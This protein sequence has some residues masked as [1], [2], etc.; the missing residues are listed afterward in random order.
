MTPE[1]LARLAV[2]GLKET[3]VEDSLGLDEADRA[4]VALRLRLSREVMRLRGVRHLTQRDLAAIL[5]MSQP[6]VAG[7]EKAKGVSLDA[8]VAAYVAL[9]GVVTLGGAGD[10]PRRGTRP[11]RIK[12]FGPKPKPSGILDRPA[13]AGRTLRRP[14]RTPLLPR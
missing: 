2:A 7:I 1:K 13:N 11:Q 8:I 9:G 12:T 3:T 5:K 4:V 14:K 6:R 10:R